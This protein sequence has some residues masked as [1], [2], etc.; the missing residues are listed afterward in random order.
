MA[1]TR[2]A[3]QHRS[4]PVA[5]HDEKRVARGLPQPIAR[6]KH[7]PRR[8]GGRFGELF[9]RNAFVG[10]RRRLCGK[11]EVGGTHRC[12]NECSMVCASGACVGEPRV[13]SH[14]KSQLAQ[15]RQTSTQPHLYEPSADTMA[16]EKVKL[17]SVDDDMFEVE[18]EVA[19]YAPSSRP[20][21]DDPHK[22]L[23]D[24]ASPAERP[25]PH[26]TTRT[27]KLPLLQPPLF[28]HCTAPRA[29]AGP[30][31]ENPGEF[32]RPSTSLGG[33]SAPATLYDRVLYVAISTPTVF[34][35]SHALGFVPA[36]I[37]G[38][39]PSFSRAGLPL[40]AWSPTRH[41]LVHSTCE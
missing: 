23:R 37:D 29:S 19:E 27:V 28:A 20:R 7:T 17:R 10:L 1:A 26:P 3:Q 38:R 14:T 41:R 39:V 12:S 40:V 16:E 21:A 18:K 32:P 11:R 34:A 8:V 25:P 31:R 9:I 15:T 24:T 22:D 5:A 4:S 36:S 30:N 33:G 6:L 35:R 13:T 2:A